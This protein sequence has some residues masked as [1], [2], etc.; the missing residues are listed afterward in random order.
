[1]V[2]HPA[3]TRRPRPAPS[4]RSDGY[5][6]DDQM[7]L[8]PCIQLRNLRISPA[9]SLRNKRSLGA[10][11]LVEGPLICHIY[12]IR[13]S[14]NLL[15]CSNSLSYQYCNLQRPSLVSPCPPGSALR[16]SQGWSPPPP[17]SSDSEQRMRW[18][19]AR[20]VGHLNW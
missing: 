6:G 11:R 9:I 18:E 5:F 13:V 7:D 15:E 20:G 8:T 14:P 12:I 19:P 2:P 10:P 4:P 16:H 1:M 3:S 17:I